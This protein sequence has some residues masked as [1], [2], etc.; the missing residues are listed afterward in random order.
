MKML[1]LRS[2]AS[3]CPLA[4]SKSDSD[5]WCLTDEDR[6]AAVAAFAVV[7]LARRFRGFP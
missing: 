5:S 3:R 7:S 2:T 4:R 6:V 1:A